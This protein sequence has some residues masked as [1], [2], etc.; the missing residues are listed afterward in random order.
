[1]SGFGLIRPN[2][3]QTAFSDTQP[4][5]TIP[6]QD[7]QIQNRHC[8][9]AVGLAT[10]STAWWLLLVLAGV[11][12]RLT[13][14]EMPPKKQSTLGSF[15]GIM[16]PPAKTPRTEPPSSGASG[17]AA[18]ST[19]SLNDFGAAGIM[20]GAAAARAASAAR[21]EQ[22]V[23]SSCHRPDDTGGRDRAQLGQ[24]CSNGLCAVHVCLGSGALSSG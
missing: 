20:A 18:R 1:V 8:T 13:W 4:D 23:A 10:T 16:P 11:G 15:W 21:G 5:A 22:L 7:G 17:S 2:L 3:C 6:L 12:T 14:R 9:W 24:R 19:D